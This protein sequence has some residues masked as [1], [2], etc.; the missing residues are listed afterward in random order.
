MSGPSGWSDVVEACLGGGGLEDSMRTHQ[1]ILTYQ[2]L[3]YESMVSLVA[4]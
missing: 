1:Q 3:S 2:G 4:M